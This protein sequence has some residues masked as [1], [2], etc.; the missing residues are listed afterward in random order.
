MQH[1]VGERAEHPGGG[2][3]ISRVF[4]F[5]NSMHL[6]SN[7]F[8]VHQCAFRELEIESKR[9][10]ENVGIFSLGVE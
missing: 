2:K 8:Y 6:H 3:E 7:V 5:F 1:K 9:E 4:S 10:R